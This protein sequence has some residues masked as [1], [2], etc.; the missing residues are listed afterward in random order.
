VCARE[1]EGVLGA[2]QAGVRAVGSGV[3]TVPAAACA[4]DTPLTPRSAMVFHKAIEQDSKVR[5]GLW[6]VPCARG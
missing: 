2:L 1:W 5:E 4:L 6:G 3:A